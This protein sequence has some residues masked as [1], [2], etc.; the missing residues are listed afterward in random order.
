MFLGEAVCCIYKLHR[1]AHHLSRLKKK[2]VDY[3][4]IFLLSFLSLLYMLRAGTFGCE[5]PRA[6]LSFLL[7]SGEVY[8]V[9]GRF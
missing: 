5:Y 9:G 3:T 6:G 2:C 7:V 1:A 8:V 4:E